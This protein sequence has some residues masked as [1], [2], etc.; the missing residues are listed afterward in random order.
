MVIFE[1]KTK[2]KGHLK[3]LEMAGVLVSQE[4]E[5]NGRTMTIT[6]RQIL[7]YMFLHL[8]LILT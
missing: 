1:R 5:V 3:I 8:A 4:T 2:D 7:Q 6:M